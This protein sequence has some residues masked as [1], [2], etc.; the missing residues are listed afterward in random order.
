M[1]LYQKYRPISFSEMI[2][3]TE[4]VAALQKIA[5]RKAKSLA[6]LFVGPPGTG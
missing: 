3:N 2:G 5:E 4:T 6:L 1:S